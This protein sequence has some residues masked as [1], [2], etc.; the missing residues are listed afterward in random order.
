MSDTCAAAEFSQADEAPPDTQQQTENWLSTVDE[1]SFQ[2]I[3]RA[4]QLPD[5]SSLG[6]GRTTRL[7]S[8]PPSEGAE[9]G[10]GRRDQ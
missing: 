5:L 9:T 8:W 6:S 4:Q 7:H 10:F 2:F 3:G 1:E